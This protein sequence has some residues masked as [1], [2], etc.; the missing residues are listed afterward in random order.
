MNERNDPLRSTVD[1]G[2]RPLGRDP[3]A[4]GGHALGGA[5][6]GGDSPPD[7]AAVRAYLLGLQDRIVDR[8]EELD[9]G[10][11]L[12]D[13]WQREPGDGSALGSGGGIT[14]VIEDGA[15]LERG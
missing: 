1:G 13:D 14:R 10:R 9:G 4:D 11:F 6:L 7:T 12:R 3:A 8:L 5:I 15:V 2:G